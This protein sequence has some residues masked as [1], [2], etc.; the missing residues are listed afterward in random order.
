MYDMDESV[1]RAHVSRGPAPG[2]HCLT[3]VITGIGREGVQGGG[4]TY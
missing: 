3:N 2:S 4:I 1:E